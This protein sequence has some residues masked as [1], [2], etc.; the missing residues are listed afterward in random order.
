MTGERYSLWRWR[1]LF[2]SRV[3]ISSTAVMTDF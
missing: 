1:D 3:M 2:T